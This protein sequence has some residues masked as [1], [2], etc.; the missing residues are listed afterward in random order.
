MGRGSERFF[1]RTGWDGFRRE[2]KDNIYSP[3][4][5]PVTGGLETIKDTVLKDSGVVIY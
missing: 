5:R 4:A 2:K 3:L 1:P